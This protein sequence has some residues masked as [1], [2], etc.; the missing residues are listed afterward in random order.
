MNVAEQRHAVISVLVASSLPPYIAT[1][2]GNQCVVHLGFI[3]PDM[4][5]AF[6]KTVDERGWAVP[7][8]HLRVDRELIPMLHTNKLRKDICCK[9]T[10]FAIL[11]LLGHFG[12]PSWIV[13]ASFGLQ[14]ASR[15]LLNTC[16]RWGSN[17]DPILSDLW[18]S[19][20]ACFGDNAEAKI[21]LR[22]I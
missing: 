11:A 20:G 19:F 9:S 12:R 15:D 8:S 18:T 4:L 6:I 2:W 13:L 7:C 3:F 17:L 16:L 10:F 1:S 21:R 22:L 5:Y 14:N